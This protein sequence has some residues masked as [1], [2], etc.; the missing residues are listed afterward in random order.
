MYLES[1]G[2]LRCSSCCSYLGRLL[3]CCPGYRRSPE[4]RSD[5]GIF[6][7]ADMPM[8]CPGGRHRPEIMWNL[9]GGDGPPSSTLSLF[10][11]W[12]LTM[13]TQL[14][15]NSKALAIRSHSPFV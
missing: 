1:A 11:K 14:F 15:S 12:H 9:K 6:R 10:L 8:M 2:L 5:C 3:T 4:R 13:L 7:E